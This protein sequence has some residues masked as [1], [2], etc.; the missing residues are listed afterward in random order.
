VAAAAIRR[1]LAEIGVPDPR[2]ECALGGDHVR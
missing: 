1:V 2:P